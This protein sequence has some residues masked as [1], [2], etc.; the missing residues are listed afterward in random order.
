MDSPTRSSFPSPTGAPHVFSPK[1]LRE[2]YGH[3]THL[4]ICVYLSSAH[5]NYWAT[6]NYRVVTIVK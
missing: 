1:I 3:M 5:A 6:S 4:A 2:K